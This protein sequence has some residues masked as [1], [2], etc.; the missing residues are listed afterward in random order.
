MQA[1]QELKNCRK[2]EEEYT[3]KYSYDRVI[4]CPKLANELQYLIGRKF[5][6][7]ENDGLYNV[8][9]VFY[10]SEFEVVV[11]R[12]RSLDGRLRKYDDSQFCVW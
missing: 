7:P 4:Q 11:G 6:D 10:N 3:K 12:R 9:S 2:I 5:V 1:A 8:Y